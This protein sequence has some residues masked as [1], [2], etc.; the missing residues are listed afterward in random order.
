MTMNNWTIS[1]RVIAGFATMLLIIIALG[2]FALWRLT[3][4]AQNVADLADSS[5]PSVLLLNEA[6]KVSRG[7][8]ID[9]LQIDETG[10]SERNAA[11][12]QRITANTARRDEL[13]KS[14]KDRG[15]IADD[16]DRRLFEEVQ[17][18]KEIMTASR[19]RAI[20]LA[21]EGNAEESRK[22]QQEAVIP[23]YEKYL[24]AIDIT[25]D[26]KAKLGQSTADAGKASALFSVRLIG[27]ALGLALLL[28]IV[29]AWQVIRSTNR[30]LKDITVNLDRGALQ[31][32]SAARQVSMAS[33]NL[34]SGASEQ[35]ASVEETSTSL[36][37][38]SSMIRATAENA[39]KAKELASEA[40]S[41]AATGS[42][43]MAEMT[44]AMAAIDS[45]S[46]EVAKIVKNIDE[47]AF[48]TNILA[49]NA[50]VEAARAGEAGAGFAVVA[51]EVRSLAQRS[52]AA[53]KETA[54]K[55][56]AAIVNSR[57]GSQ[58]TAKVEES[59][60]QIAERVSTTDSLV[61]EIAT[62]AREQAQGIEQINAAIAQ[63]DKV[64]QSNSASA[65]ESASAAE[66]LDAQAETLKDQVGKL[67]L[68]VGGKS[69]S[70]SPTPVSSARLLTTSNRAITST[71]RRAI[72]M[73]EDHVAKADSDDAHFRN[74]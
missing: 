39:E 16:E 20:E 64:S 4:L 1:R 8:L 28:T 57:K 41:V 59:L 30:A 66:E 55:I 7:N 70:V 32:A 54:D 46:A 58:C 19:T 37:E 56:E 47:I 42:M 34:A 13:L 6:S 3:G 2:V 9:L 26:Y 43:T 61:A 15:L 53:A 74:F 49:L 5:L 14:Y 29:L 18:A 63:M 51:D 12:E 60:A 25:V 73:P 24:K 69:N 27:A 31:T 36:E 35:A 23:D 38:M 67:R 45:S 71:G 44:H 68:L 48:Q 21:H 17:R 40:R 11:H 10:P 72:P 33:Q 50:A 65:E 62:A 52:A 22:V